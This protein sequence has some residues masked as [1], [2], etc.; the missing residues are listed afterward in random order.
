M[1]RLRILV[2]FGNIPLHGQERANIQVMTCLKEAGADILFVTNDEYGHESIQPM[3]D[4]LG[5]RWTTA[6]FPR[7]LGKS[8]SVREWLERFERVARYNSG[9]LKAIR[10]FKPTHIHVAN[11]NHLLAGLP[12][13]MAVR[14]P[15]VYRLGDEPR[16]HLG[17]FRWLWKSVFIPRV[18]HFVCIS[19][20]IEKKLLNAGAP[21]EKTSIIYNYPPERP[22]RKGLGPLKTWSGRTVT[23]VGQ[24]TTEKGV[25]VLFECAVKLCRRY[26]D[27]RFVFAGDFKWRNPFAHS[28]IER[29]RE[30]SLSDRILFPGFVEDVPALLAV[31]TVH[32]CPSVWEEPLG[33]VVVEAKKSGLPSIVFPSGGLPELIEH[34]VDGFICASKTQDAL[35]EGL[36]HYLDADADYREASGREARNSLNRLGITRDKFTDAWVK[37]YERDE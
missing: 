21:R 27:L 3:L 30:L 35:L 37:V 4:S 29:A 9:L 31:S 16:S 11:E 1:S 19:R 8:T 5:L 28:L 18:S 36:C 13:I 14:T 34:E 33:N 32:V 12:V 10:T 17:I 24:L 22:V 26:D 6:R 15:V 7:L 2:V 23:Y 20:F 25:D